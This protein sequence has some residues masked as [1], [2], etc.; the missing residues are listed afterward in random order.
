MDY[1]YPLIA[2]IIVIGLPII[3]GTLIAMVAI[4]KKGSSST[5]KKSKS[6]TEET[7]MIQEFYQSLTKMESR[8]ESLETILLE[9]ERRK[10]ARHE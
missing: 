8:I 2:I 6:E 7:M 4:L 9:R 1:F 5:K 3:C 10:G